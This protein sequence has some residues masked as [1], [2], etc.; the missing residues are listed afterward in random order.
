MRWLKK[1]LNKPSPEQAGAHLA[2]GVEAS[3]ADRMEEALA[4]Y[5]QAIEC[6]PTQPFAHL[7][8]ALALQDL[9]NRDGEGLD[10]ETRQ[11][12][13]EEIR[14]AFER[15][16][17]MD[18]GQLVGWRALGHVCRRL[19]DWQRAEQAFERLLEIAPEDFEHS[20]EAEREL[21][22]ISVKAERA[23][24]LDHAVDLALADEPDLEELRE[25]LEQVEPLLMHPETPVSAF[26][27]TGVLRRRLDDNAGAR[28]MFE[29][30]VERSPHH[31]DARRELAT[32]CIKAGEVQTALE[33]SVFAYRE[34]PSNAALVCNVGVC[35]LSLGDLAQ[36]QEYLEMARGLAPDNAIVKRAWAALREA[37]AEAQ[38]QP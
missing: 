12:R 20:A 33:H 22:V 5:R 15:A 10:A 14:A 4:A 36:A 3:R 34:D 32:L 38:P 31:L 13:L 11:E 19:S 2:R 8:E 30:C 17:E 24:V 28:E 25:S 29:A 7:N 37:Q 21:K 18:E 6:D 26:W 9:Y 35:H 16:L 27:A 23:R 1:L